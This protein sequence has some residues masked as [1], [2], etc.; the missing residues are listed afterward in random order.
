VI[1]WREI[2]RAVRVFDKRDVRHTTRVLGRPP[3]VR[4]IKVVERERIAPTRCLSVKAIPISQN[5]GQARCARR[6]SCVACNH[7]N[8]IWII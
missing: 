3:W 6:V 4:I 7:Q 5:G 2:H 1:R 8:A